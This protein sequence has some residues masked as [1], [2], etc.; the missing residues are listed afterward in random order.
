[1]TCHWS[2]KCLI[3]GCESRIYLQIPLWRSDTNTGIVK[4]AVV[5]KKSKHFLQPSSS[6]AL[7]LPDWFAYNNEYNIYYELQY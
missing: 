1:M 7:L 5:I 6:M 2:K 3:A 4:P